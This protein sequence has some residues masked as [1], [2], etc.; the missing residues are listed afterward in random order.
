LSVHDELVLECPEDDAREVALWLKEK[1]RAAI[2][3]I[4][5]PELGGPKSVEVGYGPSWG[6]CSDVD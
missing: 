6:E 4:L 5:G 2:E 1:M 3:E